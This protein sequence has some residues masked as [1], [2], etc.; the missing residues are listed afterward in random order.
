MT[1]KEKMLQGAIFNSRD[2]ELISMYYEAR[3][4]LYQF[5]HTENQT[6]ERRT[7]ILKN[8]VGFL[9]NEVWIEAPFFC[10]YGK[11]ISIGEKTFVNTNCIFQDNNKIQIGKNVLIAPFV[12]IY[13]AEH[14]LNASERIVTRAN[15]A[16]YRTSAKPVT[17]GDNV[18]I[19]GGTIILP[20]IRIGN[21]VTIGAGSV[22]TKDIADNML[23]YGN[24]CKIIKKI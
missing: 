12:Q 13:T 16:P 3:K 20:G 17:I 8:L 10:E 21:N 9:G 4:L 22:V 11:N 5:N 7:E 19:G 14:P 6:P 2:E 23:A 1:E 15:E 24:P 18:W